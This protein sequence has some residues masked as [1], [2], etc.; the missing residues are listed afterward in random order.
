MKWASQEGRSMSEMEVQN[1]I[2]TVLKKH[3]ELD[4][5]ALAKKSGM[6]IGQTALRKVLLRLLD[7]GYVEYSEDRKLVLGRA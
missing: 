5:H 6:R 2:I 4:R 1:K 7:E 3:A